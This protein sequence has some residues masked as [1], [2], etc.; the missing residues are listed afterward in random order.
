M[1]IGLAYYSV[2]DFENA[3]TY[4]NFAEGEKRWFATAGK[5]IIYLLLGNTYSR[6][7]SK[8]QAPKY[9]PYAE[10]NYDKAL[11][12]DDDYDRALVGQAGVVFLKAQGDPSDPKYDREG[13]EQASYLLDK[14][15]ILKGQD[16]TAN[17]ET[18][19]HFLRGQIA[20]VKYI[21][22]IEGKD[23]LNES[24][25]EFLSVVSDYESGEYRVKNLASHAYARLGLI[26]SLQ[27]DVDVSISNIEKAIEIASPFY[28]G[29][30]YALLGDVRCDNQQTDL[31]LQAY[32][33]ALSI[34]EAYADE[35]RTYE[36][37]TKIKDA[38]C[39]G[40]SGEEVEG[41]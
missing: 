32:H 9:L 6:L 11:K 1:T 23:S 30:Y 12:L 37:N 40:Q 10:Q 15:L 39:R 7:A 21:A 16:D 2:D 41:G 4:F 14:A 26:S 22:Q 34:A 3:L 31:A 25:S 29:E 24:Y 8:E 17:I 38:D 20:F 27:A 5:E 28:K 13:L 35:K 36:Y 33:E 19:V 18:K